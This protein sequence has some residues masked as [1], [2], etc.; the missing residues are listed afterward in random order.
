M[1]E[2]TAGVAW[3]A[4]YSLGNEEIDRQ[5]KMLFALVSQ[6]TTACDDGSDREKLSEILDFLGAYTQEHFSFEETLQV[7]LN[8]PDYERHK[9]LHKAFINEVCELNERFIKNGSSD[10]LSSDVNRIVVKWLISHI[11][12]EDKKIGDFIRLQQRLL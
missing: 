3:N 10:K 11:Q 12:R 7:C 4:A 6:L 2:I 9:M 8:Y 5:H 1:N